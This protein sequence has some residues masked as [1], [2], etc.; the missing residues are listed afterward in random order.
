MYKLEFKGLK[1]L[2]FCLVFGVAG[3]I[4]YMTF[5]KEKSPKKINQPKTIIQSPIDIQSPQAIKLQNV[6]N[7]KDNNILDSFWQKY[8]EP[9]IID[10]TSTLK[11]KYSNIEYA[12][13]WTNTIKF[14]NTEFNMVASEYQEMKNAEFEIIKM[15]N[16]DLIENNLI[17]KYDIIRVN[18]KTDFGVYEGDIPIG[19]IQIKKYDDYVTNIKVI[20]SYIKA[21]LGKID[22][23]PEPKVIKEAPITN[24]NE[25][26]S[27]KYPEHFE[28]LK[29]F[30][31]VLIEDYTLRAQDL[32]PN[33]NILK[34]VN[35]SKEINYD[36][37]WSDF[38]A[39]EKQDFIE[40]KDR[41][42]R[43]FS[44]SAKRNGVDF[45]LDGYEEGL[46]GGVWR[47]KE[48][49]VELKN[50]T[51]YIAEDTQKKPPALRFRILYITV[52]E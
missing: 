49:G 28:R 21:D 15:I 38:T 52:G 41:L 22:D 31:P 2:L 1:F 40:K 9:K 48:D 5:F 42:I 37:F 50:A 39:Q 23:I 27:S 24:I 34:A 30:E 16:K 46:F 11:E 29:E 51:L 10:L 43:I 20:F 19:S 8:G 33:K 18:E 45:N 6:A 26:S 17:S 44:V 13:V 35:Y 32:Y 47:V 36:K 7:I 4:I 12:G 14:N 3:I 25:V